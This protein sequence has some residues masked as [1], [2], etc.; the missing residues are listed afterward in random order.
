MAQV[1]ST[2]EWDT[3]DKRLKGRGVN[4]IGLFYDG[5]RWWISALSWENE[6]NDNPIP[7]E[8]LPNK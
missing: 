2:Y 7:K 1:F 6:H 5:E 3:A 4:S 8:F